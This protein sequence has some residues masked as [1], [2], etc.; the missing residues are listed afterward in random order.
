MIEVFP[1]TDSLT[2]K[3][4]NWLAKL[5]VSFVAVIRVVTQRF[6]PRSAAWG[7][8]L[9]D[10][11]NNGYEGDYQT[12]RCALTKPFSWVFL[13]LQCSKTCGD[14][15]KRRTVQCEGGNARCDSSSRP[16]SIARCNLG[17]CPEWKPGPWSKVNI[18][19]KSNMACSTGYFGRAITHLHV[20]IWAAIVDLIFQDGGIENVY[21][22]FCS[23]I[24]PSVRAKSNAFFHYCIR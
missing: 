8:A 18:K 6:S 15:F 7:E 9:G 12:Y 10:D 11:P 17:L 20:L 19:F 21:R 23:E 22:A 14:G 1:F 4:T 16:Q 5:T 2:V 24:P 13:C 3:K